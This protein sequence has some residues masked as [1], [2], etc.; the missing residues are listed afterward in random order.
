MTDVQSAVAYLL[1]TLYMGGFVLVGV[2]G[3]YIPVDVAH[4]PRG[5][6]VVFHSVNLSLEP[7]TR[8]RLWFGRGVLLTLLIG[9]QVI[10]VAMLFD[11]PRWGHGAAGRVAA[12]TEFVLLAVWARYVVRAFCSRQSTP[13]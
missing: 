1:V 11:P 3:T 12:V 13:R 2:V 7:R 9:S 6:R 5:L 4:L 8:L 10:D